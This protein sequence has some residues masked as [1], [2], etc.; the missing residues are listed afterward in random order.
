MLW[1]VLVC[2]AVLV[3]LAPAA[4]AQNGLDEYQVKA[5]FLY[6]FTRFV[7]WPPDLQSA[8]SPFVIG[9]VGEDPFGPVLD[10]IVREKNWNGHRIV[11]RRMNANGNFHGCQILYIS[12][13]ERTE[14]PRILAALK[15]EHVLT[16][17]EFD[18]FLRQGGEVAFE[19]ENDMVR[20]AI[21][22]KA[23]EAGGLKLSSR[24]L[25]V[26]RVTGSSRD[27]VGR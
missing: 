6:N 3:M 2:H 26:A 20:I 7:D 12:N 27:G 19:I 1:T 14:V 15:G 16:V 11:V 21:N 10:D 23:A 4:L 13:S 5:A 9:I 18:R 25:A 24:L 8:S 22:L 17:G